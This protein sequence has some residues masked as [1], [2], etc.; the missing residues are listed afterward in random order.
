MVPIWVLPEHFLVLE[1]SGARRVVTWAKSRGIEWVILRPTL[2]YGLGRD[3]NIS[4]IARFIR[5]FSFF[6]SSVW[7]KVCASPFMPRMWQRHVF[8]RCRHQARETVLT[9]F[10]VVRRSPAVLWFSVCLLP[11]AA[12]R[13]C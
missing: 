5:R 12:V 11:L 3:K 1:A 9:T 8:R 6:L 10:L 2:I 7:P 13:A 4:E